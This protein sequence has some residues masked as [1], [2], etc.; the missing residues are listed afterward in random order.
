MLKVLAAVL[1]VAPSVALA[2]DGAGAPRQPAD[3]A[4]LVTFDREARLSIDDIGRVSAS[5]YRGVADRYLGF[6]SFRTDGRPARGGRTALAVAGAG[7]EMGERTFIGV[8][9]TTKPQLFAADAL[10]IVPTTSGGAQIELHASGTCGRVW[11]MELTPGGMVSV[12]GRKTAE[13]AQ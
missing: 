4:S 9:W 2:S 1:A 3:C 7:G 13:L 10:A 6:E 12:N 8:L 5:G 11:R